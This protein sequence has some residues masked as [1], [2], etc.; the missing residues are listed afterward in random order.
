[1]FILSETSRE[2][3][4]IFSD[5]RRPAIW[6]FG[7]PSYN[8]IGDSAIALSARTLLQDLFPVLQRFG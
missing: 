2:M 6:L 8:N 7:T 4:A 3:L 1:M 5:E